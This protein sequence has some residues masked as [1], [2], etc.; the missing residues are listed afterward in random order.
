MYAMIRDIS[1]AMTLP[2]GCASDLASFKHKVPPS[3]HIIVRHS[4]G[5][6]HNLCVTPGNIAYT[7]PPT[8]VKVTG[9]VLVLH[10]P[11]VRSSA[12]LW[13]Q[14]PTVFD[15]KVRERGQ[16]WISNEKPWICDP[17]A[18]S[19]MTTWSESLSATICSSSTANINSMTQSS[20]GPSTFT[21]RFV[22]SSNMCTVLSSEP[23]ATKRPSDENAVA[24]IQF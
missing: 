19:Q 18:T 8:S 12:S 2:R 13:I 11:I 10:T 14:M 20:C 23:E 17:V 16:S 24:Q 22:A 4:G 1:M 6:Q 9:R 15:E 21:M 5:G 3:E 7:H